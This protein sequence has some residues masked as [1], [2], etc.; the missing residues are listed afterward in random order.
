MALTVYGSPQSRTTRVLWMLAELGVPFEHVPIAWDDPFL[1]SPDFLR[2]NPAGRIPAIVDDGMALSESLAINLY[3]AKRYGAAG[4]Q[5]LY[6]QTPQDE[7]Q[8]WSWMLWTMFDLESSLDVIRRHRAEIYL[9]AAERQPAI[10]DEAARRLAPGLALLDGVL[11]KAPWLVGDR[12][13]VADLNVAAV[14]SPSRT[15][16]IEMNPYPALRGWLERCYARP[17]CQ[18]ARRGLQTAPGPAPGSGGGSATSRPMA[19]R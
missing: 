5:G 10:A 15:S 16:L 12:F 6:P 14:L 4:L 3:L 2:I 17:A 18:A 1:K 11:A 13:S 7:A 19:S 8:T 9:P